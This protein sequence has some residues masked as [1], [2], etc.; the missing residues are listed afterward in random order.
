MVPSLI[1]WLAVGICGCGAWSS[2]SG[3]SAHR[4]GRTSRIK[5]KYNETTEYFHFVLAKRR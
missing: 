5:I 4:P 2:P 1:V 3:L